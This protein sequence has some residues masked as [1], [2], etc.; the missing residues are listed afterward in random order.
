MVTIAPPR[1][2]QIGL[3]VIVRIAS[4]VPRSITK[5]AMMRA[6][7]RRANRHVDRAT[8]LMAGEA[9]TLTAVSFLHCLC[10]LSAKRLSARVCVTGERRQAVAPP[11]G[12]QSLSGRCA[13]WMIAWGD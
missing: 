13:C 4:C 5:A 6:A 7:A 11:G 9:E 10:V 12:D 3:S 8:P 2:A 1:A